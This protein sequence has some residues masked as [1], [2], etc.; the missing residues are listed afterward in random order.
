MSAEYILIKISARPY[1]HQLRILICKP[2]AANK[3]WR[4]KYNREVD[5]LEGYN[6]IFTKFKTR[7]GY[8]E[9][10]VWLNKW[11]NT[12]KSYGIFTHELLHFV[13]DALYDSGIKLVEESEEAFTY[14]YGH[15]MGLFIQQI[16]KLNKS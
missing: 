10:Y 5:K 4:S 1:R 8:V 7:G 11:D 15:L 9:N 13:I 3:Y 12:A 14:Y 2:E 16:V 6:G